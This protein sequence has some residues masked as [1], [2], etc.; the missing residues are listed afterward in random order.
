MLPN[1]IPGDHFD[2]IMASLRL[3]KNRETRDA[4][5]LEQWYLKDDNA[6]PPQYVLQNE[7]SVLKH[8]RPQ[9][10]IDVSSSPCIV[11]FVYICIWF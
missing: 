7:Q 4:Y 6:A 9:T 2:A 11:S 5:H 8:I 3:H 1:A 10:A